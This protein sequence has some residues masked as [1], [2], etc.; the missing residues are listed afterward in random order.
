[1]APEILQGQGYGI[2][3]DIYSLGVLLFNLNSGAFPHKGSNF[4]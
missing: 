2:E 3:A 4:T 1:M